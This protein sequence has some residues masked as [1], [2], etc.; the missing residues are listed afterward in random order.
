MKDRFVIFGWGLTSF[1]IFFSAFCYFIIYSIPLTALGLGCI[2]IGLTISLIPPHPIPNKVVKTILIGSI[3]S[4]EAI[5]EEFNANQEALYLPPQE[6]KIYAYIPLTAN[7][8]IPAI[9]QIQRAPKRVITYVDG[10]PGLIIYPPGS[11]LIT[12]SRLNIESGGSLSDI[13]GILSDIL[14]DFTELVSKVNVTVKNNEVTIQLKEIKVDVKA[15]RFTRILGSLP[16][17]IAACVIVALTRKPVK[18]TDEQ[19]KGKTV[20]ATLLVI[21]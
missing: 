20:T 17:S 18:V 1:G 12:L 15:P 14:I 19:K 16:F 3:A 21:E 10:N 8:K 2:I 6:G 13:E 11:D 9:A 5:L 4:I 7:P